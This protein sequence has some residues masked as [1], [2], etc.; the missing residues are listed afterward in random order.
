MGQVGHVL[1]RFDDDASAIPAVA[2]VGSAAWN[3][4]LAAK[5]TATITSVAGKAVNF[6]AIDEH[7]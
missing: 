7:R 3:M 2:P 1:V 4:S 5:R 6:D